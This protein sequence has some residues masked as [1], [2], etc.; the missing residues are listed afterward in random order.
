MRQTVALLAVALLAGCTSYGATNSPVTNENA[1]AVPDVL[2]SW[3]ADSS[4]SSADGAICLSVEP[5]GALTY[6]IVPGCATDTMDQAT[7]QF[8]RLAGEL[9]AVTQPSSGTGALEGYDDVLRLYSFYRVR[10]QGESL[11]A[12]ELDADSLR[13]YLTEHP[14]ELPFALL[15]GNG[16]DLLLTATPEQLATFLTTHAR[17]SSLWGRAEDEAGFARAK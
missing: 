17:D 4:S 2:G 12:R 7:V 15:E 13:A 5:D 6:R 1:V 16:P 11:F 14:A 3:R 10:V 9:L 8:L